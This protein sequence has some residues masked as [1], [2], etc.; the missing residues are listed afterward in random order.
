ML[1]LPLLKDPDKGF[2][3]GRL[4][5]Y[6]AAGPGVFISRAKADFGDLGLGSESDTS[7]DIGVDVRGVSGHAPCLRGQR[8][9][10]LELPA[11]RT[12]AQGTS[13]IV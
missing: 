5:P 6:V 11:S 1:R 13:S 7:V 8:L 3:H 10:V 12:R 4:Q 9:P 2:P